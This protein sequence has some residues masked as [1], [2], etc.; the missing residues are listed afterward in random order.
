MMNPE[1]ETC[2]VSP[3]QSATTLTKKVTI[4]NICYLESTY[5]RLL[6]GFCS[7]LHLLTEYDSD[8]YVKEYFDSNFQSHRR[9]LNRC[10]LSIL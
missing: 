1:F 10:I 6:V 3:Q 7:E 8:C 5:Y 4:M 2:Y 9:I